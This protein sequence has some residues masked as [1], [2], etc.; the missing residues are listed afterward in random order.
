MAL[1]CAILED[2]PNS[3]TLLQSHIHKMPA[4]H[5]T[6]ACQDFDSLET[7]LKDIPVGL[8]FLVVQDLD[9]SHFDFLQ[10]LPQRPS[11]IVY[12]NNNDLA[13]EAFKLQAVDFL[14]LP[15]Q[16]DSLSTAVQKA[17]AAKAINANEQNRLEMMLKKKYFFV[18]SDYKIVKV[19]I[20]E[21]L[22]VEG[23]GEYIRI[24]TASQKIVTLLSL[25]KIQDILPEHQ[26]LRIHR[27]YIVNLDKINFIQ[28][29]I[30]SIGEHQL[31]ISKSQKKNFIQF[32]DKSG[33][34]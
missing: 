14:A 11:I 20:D 13:V 23:L 15:I 8:L 16:Y 10:S 5:M 19:T 30:V 25:A 34:L 9:S 7:V 33:L 2:S 6:K 4:L 29:N 32:I 21:V 24:Y 17:V 26:F 1:N 28:N 18:K 27:S 3:S 22:F 12:S 31:P